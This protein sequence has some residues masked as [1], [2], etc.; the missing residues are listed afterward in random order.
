MSIQ[1]KTIFFNGAGNQLSA[2]YLAPKRSLT[3]KGVIVFVH[4]DGEL[5]YDANGYYKPIWNRLRALGYGIFSWDKPGVGGS[6]GNWLEQSMVDRQAE[7]HDAIDYL[8]QTYGY[9]EKSI[10]LMGFSQ[11]G[12]VV[13]AVASNNPNVGF[14]IGVDRR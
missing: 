6:T 1:A 2:H 4:G 9:Q 8:Q 14:V 12:W 3:P 11:A 13:P 10:G 7:V 5:T